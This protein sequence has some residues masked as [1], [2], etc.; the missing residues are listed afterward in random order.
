MP[1]TLKLRPEV[2][3][4]VSGIRY[5][6]GDG[7]CTFFSWRQISKVELLS[8]KP[9]RSRRGRYFLFWGSAD[10]TMI[11]PYDQAPITML[12]ERNLLPGFNV[13]EALKLLS[14]IDDDLLRVT[15]W[16]RQPSRKR[17]RPTASG[18]HRP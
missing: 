1:R 3:C 10:G 5:L 6:Y 7:C 18:S 2:T 12:R 14:D 8:L 9:L 16:E 13:D 15:C 11:I 4:D 17:T